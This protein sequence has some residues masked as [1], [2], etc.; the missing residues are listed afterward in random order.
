M[1]GCTRLSPVQLRG[2]T[3]TREKVPRSL[4]VR[5]WVLQLDPVGLKHSS[6][7]FKVSLTFLSLDFLIYEME[8]T[9]VLPLGFLKVT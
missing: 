8:A 7:A 1:G 4:E 2:M 6:F 5:G 9:V 3:A